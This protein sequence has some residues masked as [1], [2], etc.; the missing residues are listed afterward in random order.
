MLH[1]ELALRSDTL[2]SGG[3]NF[4]GGRGGGAQGFGGGY[5]ATTPG[6]Q[7]PMYGGYGNQVV[8]PT[9]PSM[10]FGPRGLCAEVYTMHCKFPSG[11][12]RQAV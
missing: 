6:R 3:G 8:T 5:G 11:P 2:M 12:D 4:S 9:I 10:T 7:Q 1:L